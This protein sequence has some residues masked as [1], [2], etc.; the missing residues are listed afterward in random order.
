MIVSI[1]ALILSGVAIW[2]A[3][4]AKQIPGPKGPH[5]I[6]G[7][8]GDKGNKG[9]NGD[10]GD[11]GPKGDQGVKGQGWNEARIKRIEEILRKSEK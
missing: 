10:K 3:K 11:Q 4:T 9:Q 5:G 2:I 1:I 7:K 8:K 6:Q